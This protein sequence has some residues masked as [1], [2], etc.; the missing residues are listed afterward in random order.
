MSYVII[1]NQGMGFMEK[2]I[3][4]NLTIS[5]KEINIQ[6]EVLVNKSNQSYRFNFDN[7]LNT[8]SLSNNN[9]IYER[10]NNEYYFKLDSHNKECTYLFK[11][12]D[13]NFAIK[14]HSCK[15]ENKDN[16][17]TFTYKLESQ[18]EEITITLERK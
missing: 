13:I 16:K 10:D 6:E 17:I 18:E 9:L 7:T 1:N 12:K 11:E 14:V 3:P 15:Y 2:D 8:I 5:S 4:Y